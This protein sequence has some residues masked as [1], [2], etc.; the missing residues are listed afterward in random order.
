MTLDT[1]DT[2][3]HLDG[4]MT[5]SNYK[6]LTFVP[7]LVTPDP[8]SL[9]QSISSRLEEV[10]QGLDECIFDMSVTQTVEAG[11]ECYQE[12]A[13]YVDRQEILVKGKSREG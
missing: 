8:S 13:D 3:F 4:A 7:T 12:N 2:I 10:C 1:E 11:E 6:N 5:E 9:D